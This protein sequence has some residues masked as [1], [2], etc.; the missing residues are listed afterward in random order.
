MSMKNIFQKI[1]ASEL[2]ARAMPFAI[3]TEA[4]KTLLEF[5]KNGIAKLPGMVRIGTDETRFGS[6]DVP[7][8]VQIGEAGSDPE[9]NKNIDVAVFESDSQSNCAVQIFSAADK[10]GSYA[11][12]DSDGRNIGAVAYAHASDTMAFRVGGLNVASL[13]SSGN[14]AFSGDSA[15]IGTAKTPASAAATGTTGQV[16]WDSSYIY[17]CVAADT[18]KRAAITT[19]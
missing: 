10:T 1:V 16:A 19:W 6:A 9:W 18:W 17:V 3:K 8:H 14:P 5:A 7:L 13:D 2:V 11:F 15:T 4:G 12:A